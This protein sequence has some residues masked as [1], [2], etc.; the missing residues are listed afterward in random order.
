MC[1]SEVM[2]LC[3][4]YSDVLENDAIKNAEALKPQSEISS[5]TLMTFLPPDNMHVCSPNCSHLGSGD[6]R[7]CG[8]PATTDTN[9]STFLRLS[10]VATTVGA[11]SS[12]PVAVQTTTTPVRT[13][14]PI[15]GAFSNQSSNSAAAQNHDDATR[16]RSIL[17]SEAHQSSGTAARSDQNVSTG[18][19]ISRSLSLGAIAATSIPTSTNLPSLAAA[20]PHQVPS[21]PTYHPNFPVDQQF[22]VPVPAPGF[23]LPFDHNFFQNSAVFGSAGI[24]PTLP[25]QPL[26][27]NTACACGVCPNCSPQGLPVHPVNMPSMPPYPYGYP[28][29]LCFP[30][31]YYPSND[32]NASRFPSPNLLPGGMLSPPYMYGLMNNV[33]FQPPAGAAQPPTPANMPQSAQV[34]QSPVQNLKTTSKVYCHNCGAFGHDA[35]TCTEPIMMPVGQAGDYFIFTSFA[36]FISACSLSLSL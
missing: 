6:S 31:M 3:T 8:S 26:P 30:Q 10:T 36:R 14:R 32:L 27:A 7:H 15:L 28:N 13:A 18:S 5:H 17:G 24:T 16:R 35:D 21:F 34:L 1:S 25:M 23:N 33:A 2:Q 20:A 12:A 4:I 19:T 22:G 29:V 11:V 9:L